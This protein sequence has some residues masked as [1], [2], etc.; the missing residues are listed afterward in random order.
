MTMTTNTKC[1]LKKVKVDIF[2]PRWGHK[3]KYTFI[4]TPKGWE[5]QRLAINGHCKPSGS[6][7]LYKNFNQDDI[8]Y[9][10]DLED[11]MEALWKKAHLENLQKHQLEWQLK[12]IAVWI[13]RLNYHK[14]TIALQ[15]KTIERLK[16]GR[17]HA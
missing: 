6:P 2:S 11:L 1:I 15:K 17:I 10:S 9:P 4:L 12:R 16:A 8:G 14:P 5:I 7:I 13:N 3:D